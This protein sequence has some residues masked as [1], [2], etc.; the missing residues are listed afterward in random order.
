M[1]PRSRTV[2]VVGVGVVVILGP[3]RGWT[4][5][6]CIWSHR[7]IAHPSMLSEAPTDR[8]IRQWTP[9]V[10]QRGVSHTCGTSLTGCVLFGGDCRRR[11]G[12]R[13]VRQV[14]LQ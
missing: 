13:R 3:P 7:R 9:A 5:R 10:A 1:L 12:R 2:I 6:S 8:G 11:L 4:S 14:V